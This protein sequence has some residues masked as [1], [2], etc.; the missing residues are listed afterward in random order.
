MAE[1]GGSLRLEGRKDRLG[2]DHVVVAAASHRFRRIDGP[3]F[4]TGSRVSRQFRTRHRRAAMGARCGQHLAGPLLLAQRVDQMSRDG[5]GLHHN[6]VPGGS[7]LFS[8]NFALGGVEKR[9]ELGG[10]PFSDLDQAA[11]PAGQLVAGA[12]NLD[13]PGPGRDPGDGSGH[14]LV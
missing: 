9:F 4:L 6:P 3:R 12:G 5:C 1:S 2:V 14:F 11:A 8:K 13:D 7:G 10:H